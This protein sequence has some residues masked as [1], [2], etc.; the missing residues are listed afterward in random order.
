MENF[1]KTGKLY[2]LRR[3]SSFGSTLWPVYK[4]N[5]EEWKLTGERIHIEH[6]EIVFCIDRFHLYEKGY[7]CGIFLFK[8]KLIAILHWSVE[9]I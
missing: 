1:L 3:K 2:R 6:M 9:E 5:N 7:E 4:K 8:E